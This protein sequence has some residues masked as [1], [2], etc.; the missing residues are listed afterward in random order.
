[1]GRRLPLHFVKK[2]DLVGRLEG[3]PKDLEKLGKNE[4]VWEAYKQGLITTEERDA[5]FLRRSSTIPCYLYTHVTDSV[6][7]DRIEAY[8]KAY[9]MLYTRG[10]YLANLVVLGIPTPLLPREN[11]PET[12]T[13]IP[14]I[15]K[16]DTEVKKCFFPERWINKKSQ[17]DPLIVQ[18]LQ[19][20]HTDLDCLLPESIGLCDTGW[21]NALNHMAS[22]FLGNLQVMML[23]PL[24]QRLSKNLL[25]R[26][27]EDGSASKEVLKSCL[28][29]LRPSS[30][31]SIEAFE[32]A[33]KLRAFLG[34]PNHQYY[35]Q[36]EHLQELNDRTWTLH[37]WLQD[38]SSRLPV[39]PLSRKYAYLDAKVVK[40]LLPAKTKKEMMKATEEHSGSEL[41]KLLGLT[42]K[43]FNKR[44]KLLRKNLK[45][46][47]R[48]QKKEKLAKKW[49]RLGHSSLSPRAEVDSISTD[50]VGLRLSLKF[51]P[52]SPKEGTESHASICPKDVF[53]IGSDEGRVNLAATANENG[54]VHMIKRS[55]FY[56]H[57]RD[58]ETKRWERQ[59]MT[60]T[61]WGAAL[62]EMANAG[63][64]K[65][66]DLTTWKA[67][68]AATAKNICVL[69]REQVENKERSLKRMR[70][71]RWKKS[72]LH[73][74]WKK[75]LAPGLSQGKEKH[76]ALG[77]GDAKFAC[78]GKG[79][80]AVPT[81]ALNKALRDL[82]KMLKIK[83]R[84][85]IRP[86][87]E[88]KTTKCCHRCGHVMGPTFRPNG[89]ENLRYRLCSHC[90]TETGG[91]RRNR[92]V[93]AA[94]NMLT[95]LDREI[96]GLPRPA[97][98]VCPWQ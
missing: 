57:L 22:V 91:K 17:I 93:N 26:T 16:K 82:L 24:K 3:D 98:L 60:G 39:S 71:F 64:F 25:E 58:K 55:A 56:K 50:G 76:I 11:I 9:S 65:N 42:S 10:T 2:D 74:S 18:A 28:Y 15:L 12:T 90:A 19:A 85:H 66:T 75:V 48:N 47:Y 92:D 35:E 46:R 45:E 81:S 96:R 84:V 70:R 79:E 41:Q 23:T 32:W 14:A 31:L 68:I 13:P 27:Y 69:K 97:H 49:S 7:R 89:N 86:Q 44:R 43:C 83:E 51:F 77:I 53:K 20:N 94:K 67:T 34:I 59:Q 8:V 63:G 62:A 95:L 87:N 78:T 21:D 88:Y 4:L 61:A 30:E 40:A 6:I 54:G 80:K 33:M 37:L 5:S 52:T 73:Q 29:S 1:M 72:F 38:D 36:V